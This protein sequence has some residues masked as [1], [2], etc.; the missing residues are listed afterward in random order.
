MLLSPRKKNGLDS[1]FKEVRVFK[2]S[3]SQKRFWTPHLW[4]VPP[5][6]CSRPVVFL[7]GN[8]H[9]PEES[10]FLRPPKLVLEGAL[11]GTFPPPP[12]KSHDTFC[13][14]PCEFPISTIFWKMRKVPCTPPPNKK[15]LLN[16]SSL[17]IVASQA[18]CS[19][20]HANVAPTL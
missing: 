4:Y 18:A 8:G 1:L 6:L 16:V 19:N 14:P 20:V 7:R 15:N 13:P 11:Y 2:E 3:P 17:I 10:H 9:R 5:P 12:P